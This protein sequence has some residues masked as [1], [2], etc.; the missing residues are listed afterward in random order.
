MDRP[1][2]L[3][4]DAALGN[5]PVDMIVKGGK[6]VN[7][8]TAEIYPADIAIKGEWIAAI[9]D[10]DY[11]IGKD[12]RF[13]DA[14][15]CFLTPG[16][17][18]QH[19]HIHEC[20]LGIPLFVEAAL[21]HG[22]TAV[23]TDF[24]GESV[25]G[26]KKAIKE[27]IE[28]GK[29]TPMKFLFNLPI[30]SYFQNLPFSHSGVPTFDDMME[31]AGWDDCYGSND[32]VG[33]RIYKK[34]EDILAIVRELQKRG[35]KVCGHGGEITG[36][37]LQAWAAFTQDTDDHE[38]TTQEEALERI[39]IGIRVGAREASGSPNVREVCRAITE[40]KV[41][42]RRFCFSADL[43]SPSQIVYKGH[44]DNAIREAIRSGINPVTAIQMGTLNC[45]ECLKV[46]DFMGAIAPGK[47]A[48]IL[49]VDNL[50]EFN[51]VK[52]IANGILA[53]EN[54]KMVIDLPDCRYPDFAYSSV[55]L[56][57]K[58]EAKDFH[59]K[60]DVLKKTA[61]VRVIMVK[62]GTYISEEGEA[63]LSAIDGIVQNDINNDIIKIAS[64]ERVTGTGAMSSAF[65][66][67]FGIKNGAIATTYN[68][69]A[70]NMVIIGSN[71]EDMA[72]AANH[73]AK[74]GGGFLAVSCGKVVGELPLRI[75]GLLSD[76]SLPVVLD[77]IK[78][79]YD[80]THEIGCTFKEPFHSMGFMAIPVCL[81]AI[82]IAPQGLVDVWKEKV[83]DVI[84]G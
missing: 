48:D 45:A 8:Y 71:N 31:M 76:E 59:I 19:I 63:K 77:K 15:G 27:S 9:G 42:P 73:L 75:Y 65:L 29:K 43:V 82:K 50:S 69:Q 72:F 44:I 2:K 57:K 54:G 23:S 38:V 24:Y 35:K 10:V 33:D 61:L 66:K 84:K 25:I 46:S 53:A 11:T 49:F 26:G 13:I 7:V 12:T 67:G 3:L 81:G 36:K 78:K 40:H 70:Q 34:E 51:I 62:E 83:I 18:D 6:L 41:D 52:V 39:R 68:S 79:L 58:I 22:T 60:T 55:K 16:L 32:T 21:P 28:L 5:I 64:I 1:T 17:I 30:C 14:S 20:Q 74:I 37:Y 80:A 56:V 47:L 4:I